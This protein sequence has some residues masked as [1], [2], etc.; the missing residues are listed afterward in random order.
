MAFTNSFNRKFVA[1][2]PRWY[3]LELRHESDLE[4]IKDMGVEMT[5]V[6][7][8]HGTASC[9]ALL[10][11]DQRARVSKLGIITPVNDGGNS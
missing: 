2:K 11:S 8:M 3:A 4:R 10:D 7:S 9:R 5:N 1:P 6:S